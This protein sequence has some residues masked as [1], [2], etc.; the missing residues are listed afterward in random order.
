MHPVALKLK[1]TDAFESEE[2]RANPRAFDWEGAY[3]TLLEN[4]TEA[5]M[6]DFEQY[7]GVRTLLV[8]ISKASGHRRCWA[9][10]PNL[11]AVLLS[12]SAYEINTLSGY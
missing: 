6:T 8:S 4:E 9:V 12:Y 2:V 7:E 10:L 5:W 1:L 11:G 3:K